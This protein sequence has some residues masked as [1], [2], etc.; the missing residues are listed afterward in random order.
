MGKA[1]R[2]DTMYE[3]QEQAVT[4]SSIGAPLVLVV[5]L[6]AFNVLLGMAVLWLL[7]AKSSPGVPAVTP[8][9]TTKQ[10]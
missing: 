8:S 3:T 2:F 1:A 9:E 10:V 5:I 6:I 4:E 7:N